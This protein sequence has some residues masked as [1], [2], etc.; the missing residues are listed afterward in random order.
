[1]ISIARILGAPVMEPQ[2]KSARRTSITSRPGSSTA[3]TV[4]TSW[5]IVG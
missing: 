1:M 2:G 4:D 3:V 5:W